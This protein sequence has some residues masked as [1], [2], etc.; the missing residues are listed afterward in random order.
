MLG[1]IFSR[2][3]CRKWRCHFGVVH[4]KAQAFIITAI[5]HFVTIWFWVTFQERKI[6]RHNKQAYI[7]CTELQDT[8][9]CMHDSSSTSNTAPP[10]KT[11]Q[12]RTFPPEVRVSTI[13][14]FKHVLCIAV[15]IYNIHLHF[16]HK[17]LA[18]R[19]TKSVQDATGRGWG[20]QWMAD[21]SWVRVRYTN[22]H[23]G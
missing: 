23:L 22:Q 6:H 7:E 8:H 10:S 9:N 19:D 21:C 17:I 16:K 14:G 3:S 11:P 18:E 2:G 20:L 13:Y 12:K 4:I 1:W 15:C 5:P